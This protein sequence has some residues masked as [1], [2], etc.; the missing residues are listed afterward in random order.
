LSIA[1]EGLYSTAPQMAQ[2]Y[3]PIQEVFDLQPLSTRF[4][5]ASDHVEFL[6]AGVPAYFC[7]QAPAHYGEAHH[8]QAD[9]FDLVVPD[10]INQGAGVMAAWAWNVSQLPEPFPH[11][12]P[13]KE[14]GPF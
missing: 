1:L 10:E 4:F 9:T 13:P 12:A 8:S 3:L 7:I 2:I 6:V 11:H 14:R 5:G